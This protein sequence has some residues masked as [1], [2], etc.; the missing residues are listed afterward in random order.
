MALLRGGPFLRDQ[1]ENRQK[2][3]FPLVDRRSPRHRKWR[4]KYLAAHWQAAI[5]CCLERKIDVHRIYNAYGDLSCSASY[6]VLVEDVRGCVLLRRSVIGRLGRQ[7]F[8]SFFRVKLVP[9]VQ[10]S[11]TYH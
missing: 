11:G 8:V 10:Q 5:V 7:K 4:W 3:D 9:V 6:S 1:L 2:T